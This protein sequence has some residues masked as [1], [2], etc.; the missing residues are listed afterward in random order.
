MTRVEELPVSVPPGIKIAIGYDRS[1]AQF[2]WAFTSPHTTITWSKAGHFGTV[3]TS[4]L[5]IFCDLRYV[6]R[7]KDI[8]RQ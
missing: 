8:I 4:E 7:V 5:D 3:G 1:L 2:N 6:I